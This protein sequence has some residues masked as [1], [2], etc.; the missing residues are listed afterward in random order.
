MMGWRRG[1]VPRGF[2]LLDL[3][4]FSSRVE[5]GL[6][7]LFPDIAEALRQAREE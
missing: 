4:R 1:S 2:A 5:G 7:V 3:I 6:D